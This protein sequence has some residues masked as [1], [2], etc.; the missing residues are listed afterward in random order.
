M[1]IVFLDI[2]GVANSKEFFAKRGSISYDH[3]RDDYGRDQL[4][5]AVM[6]RLNK[7][8]DVTGAKIVIS[9]T[10]RRIWDLSQ[11]GKMMAD[12]GFKHVNAIIDCTSIDAHGS[13]GNEIQEWLDLESERK[14]INPGHDAVTDFVIIDDDNDMTQGQQGNFVQTNGKIGFSDNDLQ[15]AILILRMQ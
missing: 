2:D 1:K 4:D 7:L 14:I 13:R 6:T 12:T 9:S 15:K 11:I 3:G 10:W 8:V 5:P